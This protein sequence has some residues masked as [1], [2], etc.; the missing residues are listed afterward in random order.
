MVNCHLL[1]FEVSQ[2]I[3]NRLNNLADLKVKNYGLAFICA[4]E[5][6]GARIRAYFAK[7]LVRDWHLTEESN[8]R[9]YVQ[10]ILRV[11]ETLSN[12]ACRVDPER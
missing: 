7:Q 2:I 5:V 10:R 11:P 6:K 1:R 3:E 4:E 9:S 8:L 12:T